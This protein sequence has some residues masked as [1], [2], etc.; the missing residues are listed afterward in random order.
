MFFITATS[1]SQTATTFTASDIM[2][3]N[4]ITSAGAI[5]GQLITANDTLRAKDHVI[6]EQDLKVNGN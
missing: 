1:K 5:D 6:A 2:V 4:T 3:T